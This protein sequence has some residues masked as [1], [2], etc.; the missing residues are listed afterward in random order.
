M[1][2]NFHNALTHVIQF[3]CT[4]RRS[5]TTTSIHCLN[6]LNESHLFCWFQPIIFKSDNFSFGSQPIK[7]KSVNFSLGSSQSSPLRLGDVGSC[8]SSYVQTNLSRGWKVKVHHE[9]LLQ[10]G[11]IVSFDVYF[12]YASGF[13]STCICEETF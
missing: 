6:L 10:D 11:E 2:T 7:F 4:H 5:Y 12:V 8:C 3:V 13:M 9:G 1:Q